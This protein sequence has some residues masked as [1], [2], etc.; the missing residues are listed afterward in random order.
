MFITSKE[1]I[2]KS[3]NANQNNKTIE[4]VSKLIRD[5]SGKG[6]R[7]IYLYDIILEDHQIDF[8]ESKGFDVNKEEVTI[9]SW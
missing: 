4:S 5:A 2:E 6:E 3:E 9:I 1:A 8:I 7:C